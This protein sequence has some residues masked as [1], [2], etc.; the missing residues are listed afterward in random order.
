MIISQTP[1][2]ISFVGGGTDFKEFY[3]KQK[4]QVISATINKFI[5][6]IVK[7][8]FDNLIVLHYKNNE[9]VN[10]VD[11]I[12]HELIRESLK[13]VGIFDSIEII[14]LA[15]IPS[16]G[17]GLGS[18]SSVTVGL[19]NA[20]YNYIGVSATSE[21]LAKDACEIEINILKKPIGKQDQYIA[22]YGGL[23]KFEF[24]LD[25]SVNSYKYNLTEQEY[26]KLG[27][28]I[29]LHFTNK[30]RKADIILCEHKKN[31]SKNYNNIVE[32]GNLVNN[33]HE[34]IQIGKF[35]IIG[36]L[37]KRN[38]EIKK[39]LTDGITNNEIDSMVDM[40][41]NNGAIGCKI[42]GAGGGG[43]LMSYV[44]RSSQD[45][46]REAMS[47]YTEL[48]FMIEKF[49]SKIILNFLK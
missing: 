20:L 35:E 27:S 9:V 18:S 21:Q 2:R 15:D 48:P 33:L 26:L 5:Y 38:W 43:F 16:E 45:K 23:R 24:F 32:I 1:L 30:T 11:E 3:T 14:T 36:E 42:A 19:L 7:K 47:Q 49:G 46:Y 22:A 29:L 13:K 44:P 4:G 28:N 17:S 6:V 12:E 8:R 39:K 40:A 37:L 34:N 25:E 10:S 31:I 41:I